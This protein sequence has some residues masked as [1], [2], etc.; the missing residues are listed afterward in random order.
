MGM[1]TCCVNRSGPGD[2][3]VVCQNGACGGRMKEKVERCGAT[4]VMGTDDWGK[5]IDLDKVAE[6]LKANPGAKA[7]AFV[8]AET[9]TGVRAD[10]EGV[11][12]RPRPFQRHLAA[13]T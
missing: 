3:G 2:R 10:A 1:E 8:H 11:G 13:R 4:P 12:L 9:S 7:L 5:R 6:A